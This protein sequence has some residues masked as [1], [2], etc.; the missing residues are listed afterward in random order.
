MSETWTLI[1]E[2]TCEICKGIGYI[3]ELQIICPYCKGHGVKLKLY[4]GTPRRN[5]DSF[6]KKGY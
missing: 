1:G 6:K 4:M 5:E 3:P 2:V